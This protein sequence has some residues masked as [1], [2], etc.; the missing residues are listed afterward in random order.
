MTGERV[1]KPV[2]YPSQSFK[3]DH[4]KFKKLSKLGK[5]QQWIKVHGDYVLTNIT[6][7]DII[8]IIAG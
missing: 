3:I 8:K 1:K 5:N 2:Q 4:K 6:S 7:H